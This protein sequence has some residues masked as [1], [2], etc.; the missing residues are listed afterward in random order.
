MDIFKWETCAKF[1]QK[2]LTHS[3][4]QDAR[5]AQH[6]FLAVTHRN[7]VFYIFINDSRC[8]K[9]IKN[10]ERPFVDIL[11]WETCAKFQQKITHSLPQAARSAQHMFL[12]V[13]KPL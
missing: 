1:Q 7:Q 9:N 4:P 11:K 12:A 10:P 8:K 13:R 6:M 5:A 3:L 2:I